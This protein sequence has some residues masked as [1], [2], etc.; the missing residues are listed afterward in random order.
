VTL[1]AGEWSAT[2]TL[3]VRPDPRVK[4][5]MAEYE[6]QLRFAQDLGT[7]L[8]TLRE[9]INHL[10]E[11]RGRLVKNAAS[12]TPNEDAAAAKRLVDELS[13]IEAELTRVKGQRGPRLDS[14]L[15]SLY[16]AVVDSNLPPS[17]GIQ[18]RAAD[19]LPDV[20]RALATLADVSRRADT[21]LAPHP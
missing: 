12:A 21:F 14:K 4:T 5:T 2:E 16:K 20:D 17:T 1:T 6:A 9:G 18:E 3:T 11:V 8:R 7:R 19:L 10:R 15:S 13:A